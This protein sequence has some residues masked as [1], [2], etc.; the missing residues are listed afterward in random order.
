MHPSD[1]PLAVGVVAW[2]PLDEPSP[3]P[4]RCLCCL[5]RLF[6]GSYRLLPALTDSFR[7]LPALTGSYRLVPTLTDSYRVVPILATDR[8]QALRRSL[9]VHELNACLAAGAWSGR[10]GLGG[11]GQVVRA[12]VVRP[13]SRPPAMR[14]R[15]LD[16]GSAGG[17]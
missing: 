15:V 7:L 9:N 8:P 10:D 2:R 3:R 1:T 12:R 13:A 17:V 14:M 4:T 11:A 6:T 16:G 5:Y